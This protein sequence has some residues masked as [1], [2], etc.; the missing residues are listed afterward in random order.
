MP[1]LK[2]KDIITQHGL[3]PPMSEVYN[4]PPAYETISWKSQQVPG[5]WSIGM[6]SDLS[7]GLG[8]W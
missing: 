2:G 8:I 6:A 7:C 1:G 3:K 5:E 4:F